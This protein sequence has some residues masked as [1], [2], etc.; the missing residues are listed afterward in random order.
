[1]T[2]EQATSR[3]REKGRQSKLPAFVYRM[4]APMPD[5]VG[6]YNFRFVSHEPLC[7]ELVATFADDHK[8]LTKAAA[9]AFYRDDPK[10]IGTTSAIANYFLEVLPPIYGPGK[11]ACSEPFTD[12]ANGE[13]VYLTFRNVCDDTGTAEARYC[14]ASEVK[15]A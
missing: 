11:F 14:T 12:N 10:W 3:A 15:S 13:P 5:C 4:N 1:M 2:I 9:D 6:E 7:G 8:S